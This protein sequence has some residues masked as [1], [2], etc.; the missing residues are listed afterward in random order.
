MKIIEKI[1]LNTSLLILMSTIIAFWIYYVNPSDTL[2]CQQMFNKYQQTV[3]SY[4]RVK[5]QNVNNKQQND[6]QEIFTYFKNEQKKVNHK[7]FLLNAQNQ[8]LKEKIK[9]NPFKYFELKQPIVD[10][11]KETII[12]FKNRISR[13]ENFEELLKQKLNKNS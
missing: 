13:L 5:F 3:Q 7:I 2:V 10:Q 9:Q 12:I 8:D 1:Y 4:R 11:N 6:C